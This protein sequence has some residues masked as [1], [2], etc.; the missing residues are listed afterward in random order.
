M[1]DQDQEQAPS[2]AGWKRWNQRPDDGERPGGPAVLSGVFADREAR[3]GGVPN[4]P[5]LH[6][7]PLD[8]TLPGSDSSW[9]SCSTPLS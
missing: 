7:F 1:A 9:W 3:W 4:R 8:G 5:A 2:R 6:V